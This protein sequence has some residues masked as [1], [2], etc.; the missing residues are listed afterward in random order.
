[1]AYRFHIPMD[2][3]AVYQII[4]LGRIDA[5]LASWLSEMELSEKQSAQGER[6][7]T[8]T[9]PLRDQAALIGVLVQLYNR[10]HCLL[11]LERVNSAPLEK[12]R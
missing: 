6:I 2:E 5:R 9:G 11:G 8:L 4:V 12:E 1:M 7:S 3:P 10:G